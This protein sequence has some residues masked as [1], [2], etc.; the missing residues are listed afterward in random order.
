MA[1]AGSL[2]NV[3]VVSGGGF[4][5]L[6]VLKGLL[7]ADN[8]RV[9]LADCYEENI[10]KYFAHRAYV[11]PL[12][13]EEERLLKALLEICEMEKINTI[14]PSTEIELPFLAKH[15]DMFVSRGINVAVSS[16][17]FLK[18]AR[19]K[20]E[21]YKF[22]NWENLPGPEVIDITGSTSIYPILGKPRLGWGGRNHVVIRSPEELGK[23]SL[24]DLQANYAWERYLH[25]F[26]EY[27]I[28]FAINFSGAV[29]PLCVRERVRTSGG[30]AVIARSSSNSA[31]A[32]LAERF[33]SAASQHGG[34]GL[35]NVQI[36]NTADRCFVSDV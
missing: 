8:I 32:E 12:V 17:G 19:D 30:F 34:R 25:S 4:Q 20:R 1:D 35:F 21:L 24:P 9:V 15:S 23:Y 18:V 14:F 6:T 22:L 31:V 11:V 10:G 33:A 28:D 2:L 3:L 5:G 16:A 13:A 36:I 7:Q 29:S 26:I 27:S